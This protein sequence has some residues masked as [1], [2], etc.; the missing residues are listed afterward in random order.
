MA[1]RLEG[2]RDRKEKR[3]K[4]VRACAEIHCS[5]R[6]FVTG[7]YQRTSKYRYVDS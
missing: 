3:K 1:S 5:D 2:L 4:C 6:R 7:P